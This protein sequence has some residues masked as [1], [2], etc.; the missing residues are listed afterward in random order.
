MPWI[1]ALVAVGKTAGAVGSIAKTSPAL[2]RHTKRAVWRVTRGK[3]VL[4]IFG[5]GGVG[6]STAAKV[7][8]GQSAYDAHG[9]YSESWWVESVPLQGDI[10]G[11]LRVAPGQLARIERHWPDLFKSVV[12]GK[13]LG[14]VNIVAYG[15]HSLE[16]PS[17]RDHDLA[18]PGEGILEFASRYCAQRRDLEL[19]LLDQLIDGL[20]AATTPIWMVT[21]VNKQDLWWEQRDQVR[22]HY[23]QGD[24]A[25]RLERLS[26]RLGAASF[27]HEFMPVSL[28]ISNLTSATGEIIAATRQ[29][30]DIEKQKASLHGMASQI[31]RLIRQ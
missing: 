29:G 18:Q 15:Y 20:S 11:E 7:L 10:P 19:Q 5:S 13:A 3:V 17:F 14:L 26:N 31:Q 9:P 2:I 1:E 24:Y 4:P 8:A 16:L 27:Q 23:E 21:L 30:Y 25:T 6:K 28:A 22:R 12:T